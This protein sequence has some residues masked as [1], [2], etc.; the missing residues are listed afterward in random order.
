MK[1]IW[2]VT[3]I[4]MMAGLLLAC[5][6]KKTKVETRQKRTDITVYDNLKGLSQLVKLPSPVTSV[7]WALVPMVSH[8]RDDFGPNDENLYVVVIVDSA[9]WPVWEHTLTAIP[10]S[11][12]DFVL[13][14]EFAKKLLPP[15]WFASSTLDSARGGRRLTGDFF[16]PNSQTTGWDRNGEMIRH[17][18]YLLMDFFLD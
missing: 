17:G 12:Q 9:N 8:S 7:R 6:E 3:S 2:F 10:S 5:G 13:E 15:D 18:N 14:E 4:S 1:K 11:L 16:K